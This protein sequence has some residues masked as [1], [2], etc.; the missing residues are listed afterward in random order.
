MNKY[1]TIILIGNS[2]YS[3]E[4]LYSCQVRDKRN[5]S[6]LGPWLSSTVYL[7]LLGT[8]ILLNPYRCILIIDFV[9]L[10]IVY[11]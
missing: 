11:S 4:G 7:R 3:D 9:F 5:E 2:S 6:S 10:S 1:E 8:M